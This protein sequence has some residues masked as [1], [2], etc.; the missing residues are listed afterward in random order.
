MGA[1]P[2]PKGSPAPQQTS[3]SVVVRLSS[4][5]LPLRFSDAGAERFFQSQVTR[6][7]NVRCIRT[8]KDENILGSALRTAM[9]LET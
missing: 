1:G 2:Q 4:P 9:F 6:V 8:R 3:F 5:T 7:I